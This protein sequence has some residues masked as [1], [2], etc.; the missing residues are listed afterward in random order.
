[1]K[2]VIFSQYQDAYVLCFRSNSA[3]NS[4]N[5]KIGQIG[6]ILFKYRPLYSK[7]ILC[8]IGEFHGFQY[9]ITLRFF[10]EFLTYQFGLWASRHMSDPMYF[11]WPQT[12]SGTQCSWPL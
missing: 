8:C 7:I 2:E 10:S 6:Q 5:S 9:L 12:T 4:M 1:M 3:K 11:K